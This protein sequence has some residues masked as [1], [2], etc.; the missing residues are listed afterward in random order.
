MQRTLIAKG[1]IES[2]N[3]GQRSTQ[4]KGRLFSDQRIYFRD[5]RDN[6]LVV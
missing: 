4:S 6:Q 1:T 5:E 2:H 3:A